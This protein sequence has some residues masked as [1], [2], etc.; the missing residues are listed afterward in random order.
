MVKMDKKGRALGT[1][2]NVVIYE[3]YGKTYN[4]RKSSL[5]GKRVL[6]SKAFEKTRKCAAD[7]GRAARIGS[8]IYKA[9]PADIKERWLYQAITG[10]A[11]SLL[12][13]GKA[14]QEV[15]NFLWNK[16]IENTGAKNQ[17]AIEMKCRNFEPSTKET[18][19]K[20]RDIFYERWEEQGKSY[21]YFKRAWDRRG[22]FNKERFREILEVMEMPW[23]R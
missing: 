4:R 13:K 18:S 12:Y 23:N 15:K 9:L 1:F 6:E 7:M 22:H 17:D 11:A 20:L 19:R 2:G 16:Y 10:E 5:S 8:Y 21:Y 14:E 3:M